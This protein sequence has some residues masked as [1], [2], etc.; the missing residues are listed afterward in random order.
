M[1]RPAPTKRFEMWVSL[2]VGL[3][4]DEEAEGRE[5]GSDP[6]GGCAIFSARSAPLKKAGTYFKKFFSDAANVDVKD[7]DHYR[8]RRS[9]KHFEALLD[10]IRDGAMD[11]P[12]AYTPTTY[13]NRPA[14]TEAEEVTEFMREAHF[15]GL[16]ELLKK[17]MPRLVT[18]TYGTNPI[19]LGLLKERGLWVP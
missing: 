4:D 12:K 8:V 16:E 2:K 19:M 13:D 10:H 11:L 18:L 3:N 14:S 7:G 17:A 6:F 5:A 15:Y 9:H 1:K